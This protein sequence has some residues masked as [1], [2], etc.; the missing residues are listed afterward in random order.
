MHDPISVTLLC[1][2]EFTQP[3][4]QILWDLRYTKQNFANEKNESALEGKEKEPQA[5]C[6][7]VL[8]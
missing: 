2:A 3:L 7:A 5:L 1:G 4:P 8:A 6:S